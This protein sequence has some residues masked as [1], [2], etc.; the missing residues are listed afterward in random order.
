MC[1]LGTAVGPDE[2]SGQ[3]RPGRRTSAQPSARSC[4][5]RPNRR[6]G[7]VAHC[8]CIRHPLECP[9][10][11]AG[12]GEGEGGEAEFCSR[13]GGVLEAKSPKVCVPKIAQINVSFCKGHFFAQ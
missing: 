7:P 1:P 9:H 11:R 6:H 2:N 8:V 3:T 13:G 4:R 12:E 5:H 10:P